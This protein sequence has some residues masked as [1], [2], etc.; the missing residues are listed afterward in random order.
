MTDNQF[1]ERLKMKEE[2][3]KVSK[4]FSMFKDGH[5]LDEGEREDISEQVV[6]FPDN[7][8]VGKVSI[9]RQLALKTY[10][11]G[12]NNPVN[13]HV[14]IPYPMTPDQEREAIKYGTRI[15]EEEVVNQMNSYKEWLDNNGIDWEKIEK[16]K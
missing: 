4:T 3:I 13:V 10:G 12:G 15:C 16:I 8:A 5:L 7:V 2:K 11:F 6:Y 9:S 1:K 14:S